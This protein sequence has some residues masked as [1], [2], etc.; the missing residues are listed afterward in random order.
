MLVF[1]I[2][3]LLVFGEFTLSRANSFTLNQ[4]VLSILP[5]LI[6]L[7][8]LKDDT[9]IKKRSVF[10][11]ILGSTLLLTHAL[12]I[13][14]FIYNTSDASVLYSSI[15]VVGCILTIGLLLSGGIS[16]P[17]I[18]KIINYSF[19][20]FILYIALQ[21]LGFEKLYLDELKAS[22][23]AIVS[24][25]ANPTLTGELSLIFYCYYISKFWTTSFKKHFLL[26]AILSFIATVL[27][28]SL[29]AT[30]LCLVYP[31]L[32]M[33]FNSY[34]SYKSRIVS[35][36][37]CFLSSLICFFALTNFKES[38][39]ARL[40]IWK[41][42][43]EIF[44]HNPIT[45]LGLGVI[46][47]IFPFYASSSYFYIEQ[48]PVITTNFSHNDFLDLLVSFGIF[49]GIFYIALVYWLVSFV[50][51]LKN[52]DFS[53]GLIIIIVLI[54]GLF[55]F[56]S[57]ISIIICTL[58][59]SRFIKTKLVNI[60]KLKT[61]QFLIILFSIVSLTISTYSLSQISD[62]SNTY[63]SFIKF[64]PNDH[65][66]QHNLLSNYNKDNTYFWYLD[67]EQAISNKDCSSAS[68]LYI[69]YLKSLPDY[70]GDKSD[71]RSRIYTKNFPNINEPTY[72]LD[73]CE[74]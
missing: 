36:Y 67:M 46:S 45:G 32:L 18:N 47:N 42:V 56:H 38:L 22:D 2:L 41:S 58:I 12:Y 55:N 68:Y 28:G 74:N 6:L 5:F 49:G 52:Q 48:S 20:V 62:Q 39:L 1:F 51:K 26:F 37:V 29:L 27:S 15:P 44:H 33:F 72:W 54:F 21:K 30:V 66:Q 61:Y 4:L 60:N 11:T 34:E 71:D 50:S 70:I 24:F 73:K 43:F 14:Y 65:T 13:F 57:Y 25:L 35:I 69:G 9:F 19:A 64:I 3:I 10:F 40:E 59:I 8:K 63:S 53:E 17:S 16:R 7:F 31:M 23:G